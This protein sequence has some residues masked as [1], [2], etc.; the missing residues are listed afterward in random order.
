MFTNFNFSALADLN[1]NERLQQIKND[2]EANIE[3]SLGIDHAALAALTG[4]GDKGEFVRWHYLLLGAASSTSNQG[5]PF[6]QNIV[7]CTCN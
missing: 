6:Q 7:Y 2:L 1:I 5:T 4:D 3:S